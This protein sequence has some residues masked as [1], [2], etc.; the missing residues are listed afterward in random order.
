MWEEPPA[1]AVESRSTNAYGPLHLAGALSLG[2]G[3]TLTGMSRFVAIAGAEA[4]QMAEAAKRREL[5][6]LYTKAEAERAKPGKF[7]RCRPM[8]EPWDTEVF[9]EDNLR[10]MRDM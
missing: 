10:R 9:E 7:D 3:E 6:E 4:A 2:K 8:R 1:A 5:M